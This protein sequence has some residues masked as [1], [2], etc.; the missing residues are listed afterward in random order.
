MEP[1]KTCLSIVKTSMSKF[2]DMKS[3]SDKSFLA[4]LSVDGKI[5]IWDPRSLM[6]FS[7]ELV[8]AKPIK[9]VKSS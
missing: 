8:S 4:T 2:R 9:I 3:S 7:V 1:E 6:K 5:G